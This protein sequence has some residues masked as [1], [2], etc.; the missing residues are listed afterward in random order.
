VKIFGWDELLAIATGFL[1]A[2]LWALVSHG[3][4]NSQ[5]VWCRKGGNRL[6]NSYFSLEKRKK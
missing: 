5:S 2:I 3:W 4:V 6:E 1:V